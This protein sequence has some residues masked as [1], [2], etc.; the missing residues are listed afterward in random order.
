MRIRLS[1][2]QDN[3]KKIKKLRS[4]KLLEDWKNIKKIFY[5]QDLHYILKIIYSKQISRHHNNL[6]VTHFR[7]EKI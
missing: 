1:E 7:I 4:E 3:D 6:L 2:L 5:Y